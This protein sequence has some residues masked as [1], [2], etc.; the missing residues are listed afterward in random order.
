MNNIK[1]YE[2]FFNLGDDLV[3]DFAL[4]LHELNHQFLQLIV[5][6]DGDSKFDLNLSEILS[7]NNK[8]RSPNRSYDN[9]TNILEQ[10]ID[11]LDTRF[12]LNLNLPFYNQFGV[13]GISDKEEYG[14]CIYI[15][16]KNIEKESKKCTENFNKITI[17]LPMRFYPFEVEMGEFHESI[18]Q[19]VK[20][21]TGPISEIAMRTETDNA[22]RNI[23][24]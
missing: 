22:F 5:L 20:D 21:V 8:W 23:N 1:T 13:D 4:S 2:G 12:H 17:K 6:W 9:V 19:W 10:W 18:K 15:T 3:K 14:K 11:E 24:K 7:V 16:L